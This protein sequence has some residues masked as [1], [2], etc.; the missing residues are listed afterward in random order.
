MPWHEDAILSRKGPHFRADLHA[1]VVASVVGWPF[2]R[3]AA[4]ALEQE[5]SSRKRGGLKANAVRN[6][7]SPKDV[8]D[9]VSSSDESEEALLDELL[10]YAGLCTSGRLPS[11]GPILE[12]ERKSIKNCYAKIRNHATQITSKKLIRITAVSDLSRSKFG[13]VQICRVDLV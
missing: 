5:R 11:E 9:T 1:A 2:K 3:E 10:I 12:E 4:W 7:E 13:D 8:S 6:C